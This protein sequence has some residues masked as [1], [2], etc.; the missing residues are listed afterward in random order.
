MKYIL[1]FLILLSTSLSLRAVTQQEARAYINN[2]QYQQAVSAYRTLMQ[3]KTLAKNAECNKFFGQ[4]LCMTGAYEESISYLEFAAKNNKSGAWWY[5]G[6][7]RQHLYDFEGAIEALEKYRS[8]LPKNSTWLPRIDSIQAEC[9][10][11]LKGISHVQ[12]VAII[13]SMIVSKEMFF[14][15][16]ML[17]SESGR[18]IN[19]RTCGEPFASMADSTEAA[20]FENQTADYRLMACNRDGQYS[21]YESHLFAEEWSELQPIASIDAGTRKLCYPFLRSDSQTLFF[22]CD[23]TPGFGG[24]DIYKTHY[25]TDT[26]SYYAPERMGMPFNSP[27]DDYMM[28]IDETHQVGWWATNR[29]VTSGMV[30][31]YLFQL[32]DAPTYVEGRNPD[33]ARVASIQQTWR[34]ANGYEA[35]LEEIREAPQFIEEKEEIRILI[36]DNLVYTSVDQFRNPKAREM[37]ELSL[38]IEQDLLFVQ[39][40]LDSMRQNYHSANAKRRSELKESILQTEQKELQLFEQLQAAQKKYRNLEF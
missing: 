18:I 30:C 16:Y 11:G 7:S 36:N 5:L 9:Q 3:Q 1:S 25:N 38:R 20:L 19:P 14:A 40:E 24:L 27:F 10:I 12:N 35:L 4:A 29:N 32:E 13:D 31:I 37:Y 8:S 2:G 23:S 6:I 17:G 26:E 15:H 33:R 21:L 34:K 39:G 22:A 28:A